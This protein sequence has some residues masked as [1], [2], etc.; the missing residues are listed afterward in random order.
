MKA[1]AGSGKTFN[2]AKTYIR[3]LLQ[4][5]D[6][7]FYRHILA[8]TFTNKATDEMK[9]RILEQLHILA[10]TP[11]KSDYINDFVPSL[12]PDVAS[13]SKMSADRLQRILHDYGAFAVSTID[14]FFQQT[15]KSFSREIGQFSSYQ[16]E[17]DRE[18][19]ISES[20]DRLLDGLTPEDKDVLSWLTECSKANVDAGSGFK[21][22]SLLSDMAPGI[23]SD[24]FRETV[25]NKK[26]NVSDMFSIG[27]LRALRKR[28]DATIKAFEDEV[29]T[30]AAAAVDAFKAAAVPLEDT[31]PAG[32]AGGFALALLKYTGKG[33]ILPV[34]KPS[35][36]FLRRATDSSLWFSSDQLKHRS[37]SF[38]E[39]K[40]ASPF[41]AFADLFG[42]S[43]REYN[44]ALQI[45]D[46]IC[47]LGLAGKL[48]HEFEALMDEK[49]VLCL[50]ESNHILRD[51]IDGSDAP[52]VYEKLGVRFEDFLLDEFQDTSTIQWDNFKPLLENSEASSKENLVV[53]DVKQSIYRFRGSDWRL[54]DSILPKTF[55][56][57]NNLPLTENYRTLKEIVHFNNEFFPAAA[58]T[59]S[60]YLGEDPSSPSSVSNT[61]YADIVQKV[62]VKKI[63]DGFVDVSAPGSVDVMF[64]K[65]DDREMDEIVSTVRSLLDKGAHQSDIAVLVRYNKEGSKIAS[66]LI[67]EG[68]SIVSDDSLKVKSSAAV[69]LI[70]STLSIVDNPPVEGGRIPIAAF[71]ACEAGIEVPESYDSLYDLAEKVVSSILNVRP[72]IL[73]GETSYVQSFMDYL[74]DWVSRNGNSISAFL[75]DWNDASPNIASPAGKDAV[76][77]IT[78]HKSKG[79]EFHYVILPFVEKYE[80][81]KADI[82]SEKACNWCS[83]ESGSKDFSDADG[84]FNVKFSGGSEDTYFADSYRG[85]KKLQ[86]ID[87]FNTFYVAMTR[88]QIG[89]KVIGVQPSQKFMNAYKKGAEDISVSTMAH[90][91]YLF[92]RGDTSV[93][94]VYDFA[95]IYRK[96]AEEEARADAEAKS[97]DEADKVLSIPLG[98]PVFRPD[99]GGRLRVSSDASDYF[100]EDG[101][102][103]LSA[104]NRIR[105][106]VLHGILSSVKVPSD[107]PGA[108]DKA[109]ID[110]LIPAGERDKVFEFLKREI[111]SVS[112]RGW[113]PEDPSRVLNETSLIDTDG[114]F[115]RPDRVI[116]NGTSAIVVDYKFGQEK[117]SYRTQIARYAATLRRIGFTSVEAHLWYINEEGDDII[118]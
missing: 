3:L 58:R 99:E 78:V 12:C 32:G 98:Y 107:L 88:A 70:V 111:E 44:T 116:V 16:V 72:E 51:I 57:V 62:C 80:L 118:E 37:L 109:V 52:F 73:E 10:T 1:S 5:S 2:L 71:E 81:F 83:V 40:I 67:S 79:L 41:K 4:N 39:D 110:G 30:K 8:V 96:M 45:R 93:G 91:L 21:I 27:R 69:R 117:G 33:K 55:A 102:T 18:S 11:E 56:S 47:S 61:I 7:A 90:I 46:Q 48:I 22:S 19:L 60:T 64:V 94:E 6:P 104:S 84:I 54:L 112:A 9:A 26:L 87:T 92:T 13:I 35:A 25:T 34:E 42:E 66:R 43:F 97:K 74:Q 106:I 28:C 50:D 105:G 49:N 75:S 20:V 38:C 17:L 113:F 101:A 63:C 86:A 23:M 59:L 89:L 29:E 15:L 31:F 114:T 76:R 68:F 77:I 115:H 24:R 108:V 14:R 103:G 53:G 82:S 95:S 100:G 85:E 36:N 65:D